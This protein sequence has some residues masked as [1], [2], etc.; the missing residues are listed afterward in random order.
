MN[1][2]NFRGL[3]FGAVL[4]NVPAMAVT[5]FQTGFEAPTYTLGQLAGQDLWTGLGPILFT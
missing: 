2:C 1:L 5:L 4:F 3:L